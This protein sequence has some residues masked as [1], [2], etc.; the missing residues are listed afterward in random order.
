MKRNFLVALLL[1][2]ASLNA[3][4]ANYDFKVDNN[5]YNI[6]NDTVEPYTVE[7]YSAAWI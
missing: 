7:Y 1:L 2:L 4:C 6:T 5:C 3:Y